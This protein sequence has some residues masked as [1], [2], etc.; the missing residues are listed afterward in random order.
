MKK[1]EKTEITKEKILA[2]AITEFG[3]KGY[4]MAS[5]NNICNDNGISKGLIYHN[6]VNKD[7]VYLHCVAHCMKAFVEFMK[8]QEIKED[9][10]SYMDYRYRFFRE[11]PLLSRIFF[12][13][14]LQPKEHLESQIKNLKKEVDELNLNVYQTALKKMTLRSGVTEQEAINYYTIM[15]EMF[16]GYFGSQFH[17]GSAF[18]ILVNDHETMLAKML[19]FMLYGIVKEEEE[20]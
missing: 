6:F 12:E 1:S 15:Q 11:N 7:E 4:D 18:S 9:L 8:E 19:D 17:S 5:L 20:Q 16:N 2:A 13:T 14:V 3:T 10:Q